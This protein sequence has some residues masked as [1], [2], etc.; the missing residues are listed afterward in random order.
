[1]TAN[2]MDIRSLI[3]HRTQDRYDLYQNHINSFQVQSAHKTGATLEFVRAE[4]AHLFSYDGSNI[5]DFDGGSG[6]FNIGRNHQQAKQILLDL[7][8]VKPAN[9]VYRHIPFLAGVLAEEL[10]NK[11]GHGLNRVIFTSSG[12]ESTEA[13]L[14]IV[15]A[16][17]RRPRLLYLE[18][19]YHGASYGALSVTDLDI[20][21]SGFGPML[22]GCT[23]IPRGDIEVLSE[24]LSQGNVAGL[25]IEPIRGIDV[26]PLSIEY[27]KEAQR[28][29]RQYDVPLIVDE[30]F[31]GFGRTGTMF[32]F[33][34]LDIEPDILLL[35]K[36]LSGGFIPVGAVLIRNEW[37]QRVYTDPS[38]FIHGSTFEHNEFAMAAGLATLNIIEVDGLIDNASEMGGLLSEGLNDLAQR[39]DMISEVRSHG[40]MI[41]IEFCAP[42][43][44]GPRLIG[45]I[46]A[47]KGLLAHMFM[48]LLL[49]EHQII[50]KVV[51]HNNV[52][53]LSPP[54]VITR[55][56]VLRFL[57]ALDA[58][59]SQLT[60]SSRGI[61]RFI[62]KQL[63]K[64]ARFRGL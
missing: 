24:N 55:A 54:L 29:C 7:M 61:P 17:T 5:L 25:I 37:Y 16:A 38:V 48:M 30:V 19:D 1:M 49:Q 8:Q 27:L 31:T 9:M 22:P 14:K 6:V 64:S 18:G 4:A 39:Y 28:L 12:S 34:Q 53:L 11:A 42:K 57:F 21:A 10:S 58:C 2:Y 40:L 20:L 32:A 51:L 52:L 50:T 15:R 60:G 47:R 23:R 41:G 36:A 33:H 46:L 45:G 13:A 43:K 62:L 35:S 56:D 44:I 63:V 59:L 3:D 26:Q